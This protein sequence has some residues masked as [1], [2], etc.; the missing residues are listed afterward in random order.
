MT[1]ELFRYDGYVFEFEAVVT[2]VKGDWIQLEGTAFYPGGGGQVH[3]TGAIGGFPVTE[4]KYENDNIVHLVPGHKLSVNDKIWCSVNWE[5]RYDL[6]Q[7]HTAEHILFNALH[8]QDPEIEIVKIY[9][10]PESKYVIVNKDM[11]IEAIGKAVAFANQVIEDN[12]PVIKST[13]SRDDPELENVRIKLDRIEEDEI[14]VVEIGD[15]DI[16]ACSGIHVMETSEIGSIF[17]DRKVSAGKDGFAIHFRIGEDAKLAA[18]NLANICLQIIDILG[19]KPEDIV[20]TVQNMKNELES[21]KKNL[22]QT[23]SALLKS[24]TPSDINGIS[25]YTGIFNTGDKTPIIES[26]ETHKKDGAVSAYL[27]VDQNI[28]VILSSG[29]EK[30][31]C[32]TLM[33]SI[34]A[35]FGGRGGGKPDFAQGGIS[36]TSIADSVMD[37]MIEKIRSVFE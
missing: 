16:A 32:K 1:E 4:V 15:V 9:I 6:M 14:T 29:N 35:D 26:A 24:E 11:S 37:K 22:K 36:D 5:R 3:D 21:C 8:R 7:G 34:M 25:L 18:M 10:A 20:K 17:V 19:S 28:S 30:V 13:M 12:H 23:V 2:E 27:C 31:D 33:Q